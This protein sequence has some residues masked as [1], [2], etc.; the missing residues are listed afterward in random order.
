MK[1]V[2]IIT[3]IANMLNKMKVHLHVVSASLSSLSLSPAPSLF[4]ICGRM[5]LVIDNEKKFSC[6]FT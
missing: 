6:P 5:A 1:L 3:G 2:L 4:I